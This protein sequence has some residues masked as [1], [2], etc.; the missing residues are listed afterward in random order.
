MLR[1]KKHLK[2][3]FFISAKNVK[4]MARNQNVVEFL[5]LFGDLY[6]KVCV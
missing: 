3:F 1:I 4:N 2:T 5:T 6:K